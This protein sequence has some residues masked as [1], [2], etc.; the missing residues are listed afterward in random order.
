[1]RNNLLILL[2]LLITACSPAHKLQRLQN[3]HPYL[4]VKHEVTIS[5]TVFIPA[6]QIDTTLKLQSIKKP[7]KIENNGLQLHIIPEVNNYDTTYKIVALSEPNQ[8]ILE[9]KI[10]IEIPNENVLPQKKHFFSTINEIFMLLIFSL[11]LINL[12]I[13]LNKN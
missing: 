7:I 6:V 9:K 12:I 5:D 1:M 4:F 13:K 3:K 2:A 8:I 11:L 10:N